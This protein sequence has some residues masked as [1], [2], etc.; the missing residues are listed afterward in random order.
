MY[1]LLT[2]GQTA[3]LRLSRRLHSHTYFGSTIKTRIL[4]DCYH[5]SAEKIYIFS[6]IYFS[7]CF[8]VYRQNSERFY[9]FI[10][11]QITNA[12][13]IGPKIPHKIMRSTDHRTWNRHRRMKETTYERE[14]D[15]ENWKSNTKISESPKGHKVVYGMMR[16]LWKLEKASFQSRVKR[17]TGAISSDDEID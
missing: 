6:L 10:K 12:N 15:F 5:A 14:L 1:K 4:I 8:T 7:S 17:I 11:K 16:D 2:T 13:V 9:V 3:S